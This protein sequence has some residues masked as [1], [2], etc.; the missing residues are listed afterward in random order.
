MAIFLV[1]LLVIFI[2]TSRFLK[3]IEDLTLAANRIEEGDLQYRVNIVRDDEVG[4]LAAGFDRMRP[5][6]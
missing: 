4:I 1:G 3:P 2:I 5:T 6:V